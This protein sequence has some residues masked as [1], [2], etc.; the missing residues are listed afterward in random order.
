VSELLHITRGK[1]RKR[2]ADIATS[3]ATSCCASSTCCSG[4]P[5][6]KA[7]ATQAAL[8]AGYTVEELATLPEGANMGLSCGNP[9]V[10]ASIGEGE[11]VLDLGS[12]GGLDVFLAGQIV[13]AGGRVIGVDMTPE[14]VT[15]ARNNVAT[16]TERTGL[17]NVEFRLGEIEHLPVA[18]ESVDVIISNCVVNLSLDKAAVFRECFRVL[19]P[20]GRLSISD[21]V[22]DRPLPE[23]MRTDDDLVCGCIGGAASVDEIRSW[24]ENSGF[25]DIRV[26]IDEKSRELISRW[27]PGSGIENSVASA[28]IRGRK[29]E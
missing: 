12:G 25:Q 14:M 22:A 4:T 1:I 9:L 11:V 13:G 8:A 23:S 3:G 19:K 7:D 5:G 29:P 15:K 26:E 10:L 20:G 6:E 27:A 16:Y 28:I 17:N 24:L 21:I 18:D 2:Y